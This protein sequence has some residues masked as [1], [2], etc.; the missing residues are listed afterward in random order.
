MQI[1]K[2]GLPCIL[3]SNPSLFL[4]MSI[5]Q[6]S[7]LFIMAVI[8]IIVLTVA[9]VSVTPTAIAQNMTGGNMTGDS[10]GESGRIECWGDP[11]GSCNPGAP[12]CYP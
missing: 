1:E 12:G 4:G 9:A 5:N 8:V 3:I 10:V 11:C 7:R 2:Q 6:F